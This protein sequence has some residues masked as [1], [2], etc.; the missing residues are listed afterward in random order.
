[1]SLI[2]TEIV[3]GVK[4]V[5]Q[6]SLTTDETASVLM[7]CPAWVRVVPDID[8]L[9]QNGWSVNRYLKDFSCSGVLDVNCIRHEL[10]SC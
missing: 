5:A 7:V 10:K 9:L 2:H 1:M 4:V 8:H 6:L 3:S